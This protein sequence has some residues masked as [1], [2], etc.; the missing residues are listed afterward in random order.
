VDY[1]SHLIDSV[2]P[3][4]FIS[5]RWRFDPHYPGNRSDCNHNQAG[6]RP[7]PLR[8]CGLAAITGF[9]AGS[10]AVPARRRIQ[11]LPRRILAAF[12]RSSDPGVGNL[13]GVVYSAFTPEL[14]NQ[15]IYSRTRPPPGRG[16][17]RK[18]CGALDFSNGDCKC[19]VRGPAE[20][21]RYSVYWSS[22]GVPFRS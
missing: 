4:F 16:L 5:R 18:S 22:Y 10:E 9:D 6:D 17:S 13:D 12:N 19:Y 21:R 1:S 15:L 3:W 8:R 2:A 7:S 11:A 14:K 20:F